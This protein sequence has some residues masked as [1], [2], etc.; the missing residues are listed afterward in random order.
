LHTKS[1]HK[2][3]LSLL[4][5]SKRRS[6]NL[7]PLYKRKTIQRKKIKGLEYGG[8]KKKNYEE[9]NLKRKIFLDFRSKPKN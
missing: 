1:F 6:I 2:S 3:L 5:Q 8:K 7:F 4:H 9:E